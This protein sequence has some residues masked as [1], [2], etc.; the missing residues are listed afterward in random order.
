VKLRSVHTFFTQLA[1][2][3]NWAPPASASDPKKRTEIDRWILSELNVLVDGATKDLDAY[4]LYTATGRITS[5]VDALSNWYVRRTKNRFWASKKSSSQADL[6]SK[7]EAYET[8]FTCLT[9]LAQVMAPF[10]PYQSEEIWRNLTRGKKGA[11]ESVHL[12]DW[13]TADA[14]LIDNVLSQRVKAVRD[15]ASLGRQ[16]RT[17][18]KLKVRQPLS[19]AR[20][21]PA[22]ATL[23]DVLTPYLS[24]I[25][26]ELNVEKVEVLTT[27][28]DQFVSYRVKPNFR[29]LG[30]KGMGK[31][32]QDLKKSMATIPAAEAQA[33]VATLL[34]NG[35]ANVHGVDVDREDVEVAFDAH[36][37][38]AAA[39][40]RV[41]VVVLDTHIDDHLRDLGYLRELLNRVQNRRKDMD[42][43]VSDRIKVLIDGTER[44]KRIASQ[45][46]KMIGEECLAIDVT[47]GDHPSTEADTREVD[48]EGD[49]VRLTITRAS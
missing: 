48:V 39:G 31:Q 19:T 13:P 1:N 14:S 36:E 46:Q 4:D 38:Y 47:V 33:L 32:A 23:A 20:L 41:G 27:S 29:T 8:L 26:E 34:A 25:A 44:T 5:F 10:T 43:E 11:A 37:G 21:I 35:K 30:Q 7:D 15:L 22:D 9:T 24:L 40:D 17:D 16:V 42:L 12:T 6:K 18:A 49:T 45:H 3:D 2:A 28:A